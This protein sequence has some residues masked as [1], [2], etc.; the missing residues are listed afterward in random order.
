MVAV[1]SSGVRAC[2]VD[3][4]GHDRGRRP[5]VSAGISLAGGD[6][7]EGERITNSYVS[8]SCYRRILTYVIPVVRRSGLRK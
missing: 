8:T 6:E 3:A 1:P 5:R 4:V 7:S 2:A